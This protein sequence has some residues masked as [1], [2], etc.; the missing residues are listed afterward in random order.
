M[1]KI[2]LVALALVAGCGRS[3]PARAR[4]VFT[5]SG[6]EFALDRG[7]ARLASPTRL[8]V[9]LDPDDAPRLAALSA[10]H[11]GERVTVLADGKPIGALVL[12]APL[13]G[14][15]LSLTLD[16]DD[17]EARLRELARLLR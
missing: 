17:A 13:E 10:A 2:F 1:T 3:E 12:K 9:T 14:G 15:H 5:T 16:G 7:H 4:L 6:E 8:D 11:L